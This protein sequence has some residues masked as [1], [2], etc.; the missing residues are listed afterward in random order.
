MVLHKIWI[1]SEIYYPVKTSTG[2]YM[3]EIAE[4]LAY[5]G[6]EVHVICTNSIYS[7][8]E[9]GS[10][11]K[12]ELHNG[13]NIHRVFIPRMNKNNFLLRTLRLLMCSFRLFSKTLSSVTLGDKVFVV[14]NPAFLIL[15]MPYIAW[16]KKIEYTVLVHDIF[17]ENL[18]AIKKFSS[19]SLVY[20]YL[21]CLFDKAYSNAYQCI[22]IGRDMSKILRTKIRSNC[23]IR[24]IPTWAEDKSVYPKDKI[25]TL[26]YKS[27]LLNNKFVFQFAGNL[28][29]AQGIDNL[30]KAIE[31]IDNENIHFLFIG[32]GAKSNDIFSFIHNR[33]PKN[34]SLVG[35]LDRSQQNDFLNSCDVGIVTL[36][37]GM[38][39]LGVPSKSYNIMAAGKPILY[40]GDENSEIALCIKEYTLG[41]VVNSNDPY[42]LKNM[43]DY[44]YANRDNLY[45]IQNNART[46]A[47]TVFAKK[48][49][50][51]RYYSLFA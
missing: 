22:S 42:T 15:L 6:L 26:L 35:F 40:V 4:Y 8:G 21:K 12:E 44:I 43:I 16:R 49:I 20:K 38:Y 34:V 18:I 7:E 39:G 17:P 10:T 47:E 28:G 11:I 51:E 30:L 3:T 24:L 27:L 29:H 45:S 13:V 5:R 9:E 50:L 14:T 2:Y 48:I 31:M 41:W 46:V 32:D 23:H 36:N 1:V 19:S 33:Q 37:D 25:E